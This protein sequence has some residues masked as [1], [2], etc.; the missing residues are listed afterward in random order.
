MKNALVLLLLL[1]YCSFGQARSVGPARAGLVTCTHFDTASVNGP[2]TVKDDMSEEEIL[3]TARG[4]IRYWGNVA[5]KIGF[6]DIQCDQATSNASKKSLYADH[7]K[8]NC[9]LSPVLKGDHLVYNKVTGQ[10]VLTGNVTISD[11]GAEKVIGK[12]AKLD[13]T[14]D[15]YYIVDVR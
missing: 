6:S 15:Q 1:P 5:F 8:I 14:H 11:K 3:N 12:S 9:L 13:L 2:V 4:D 7:V 10:G